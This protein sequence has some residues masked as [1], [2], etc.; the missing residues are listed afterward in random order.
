MTSANARTLLGA[1][2]LLLCA[3]IAAGLFFIEIPEGNQR[4]ADIAFGLVLGW[5]TMIVSFHFGSSQG[6]KDK[7]ETLQ[8][9]ASSQMEQ[10]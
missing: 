3:L 10:G 9:M 7:T 4:I 6:S 1:A 5:G 8:R 2:A